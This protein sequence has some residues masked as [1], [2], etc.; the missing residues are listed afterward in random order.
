MNQRLSSCLFVTTLQL[1]AG[2]LALSFA[3]AHQSSEAAP[4]RSHDHVQTCLG[5]VWGKPVFWDRSA[6]APID[7]SVCT[8]KP[9]DLE[10][11]LK[12]QH[13]LVF[14][15]PNAVLL[16]SDARFDSS[17]TPFNYLWKTPAISIRVI[18][19]VTSGSRPPT[20]A[21]L[22]D[23]S[24]VLLKRA[25]MPPLT[26]P[27]KPSDGEIARLAVNVFIEIHKMHPGSD[28][29]SVVALLSDSDADHETVLGAGRLV[30]GELEGGRLQV[31][32][33]SPLLEAAMAQLGFVDLLGA[34]NLQIMLTSVFGM[35]NH[36]AFYAFDLDGHEI[37]RQNAT[38]EAFSDLAAQSFIA[39]PISTESDIK[40]TGPGNGPKE[41]L[42]TTESGKK[43]RY[44]LKSAHFEEVGVARSPKPPSVPRANALNAEGMKLM[45]QGHYETA[46]AKFE[47]A[48]QANEKDSLF[49]DNAGFAYYKLERY[50]DSLYWFNKAIEID[51]NRAVAYLNLADACAKLSR[52]AEA[53][54]AY[55]KYLELAPDSKAA[56]DVKKKLD[57]LSL[58]P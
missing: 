39:C 37:S 32:W 45:Q 47:E 12:Q 14:R 51:P 46:A 23:F 1:A 10:R 58:T 18:P 24:E 54:D 3:Y 13:I 5:A 42:T 25:H 48:A 22:K 34:G 17:N 29:E 56:A 7:S 43:V 31:R 2:L 8:A 28:Q 16:T 20:D 9:D 36:T 53:R 52:N 57:A 49:A 44:V 19:R 38:C 11:V 35:G 21:E 40:I 15:L 4:A 30:Y 55:K 41:L 33:E 50:Q 27:F 6:V 26:C